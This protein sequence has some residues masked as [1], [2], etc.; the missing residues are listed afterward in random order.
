MSLIPITCI[1]N[2]FKNYDYNN[3][4]IKRKILKEHNTNDN[5]WITLDNNVYSIRKDDFD[6]LEIFKDFYGKDAKKY[7]LDETIFDLKKKII[8][9][10]KLK[11]RK[12]GILE[13]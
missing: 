7:L 5:A 3:L 9:L 4:C 13:K 2:L 8:I 6:L 10:D 1:N 11:K 12:I